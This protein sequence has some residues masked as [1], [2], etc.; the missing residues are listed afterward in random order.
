MRP[1]SVF[2]ISGAPDTEVPELDPQAI[3]RA[4]GEL[5]D[6]QLSRMGVTRL[7]TRVDVHLIGRAADGLGAYG[8]MVRLAKWESRLAVR[9][10][11]GLP[12][13]EHEI[14]KA[15]TASWLGEAT[16]FAGVWLRAGGEAQGR[17]AIT[18][19]RLL[20]PQLES[21]CAPPISQPDTTRSELC[22]TLQ[23]D[24]RAA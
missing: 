16:H 8:A 17:A 14:R 10:L 21:A 1:T 24:L 2:R 20:L 11:A 4:Y 6:A 9:L 18:E 3:S 22:W 13:L 5:I 12:L 15:A 23:A 7:V 19:L